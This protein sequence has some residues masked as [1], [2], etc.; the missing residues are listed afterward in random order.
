MSVPLATHKAQAIELLR[1]QIRNSQATGDQRNYQPTGLS[2]LDRLLPGG[3]I[4]VGS[5]IEWVSETPGHAATSLALRSAAALLQRPGCIAVIDEGRDFFPAVAPALDIPLSRILLVQVPPGSRPLPTKSPVH[6]G[7]PPRQPPSSTAE[8]HS[9]ALWALEQTA[10]CRGVRV[11]LGWLDRC[12]SAVVRRLQLAV[13]HSGVTVMLVRPATALKQPS[14]ADLRLK[15]HA[16]PFLTSSSQHHSDHPLHT[17]TLSPRFA[18]SDTP[19]ENFQTRRIQV[20]L[21]RVRQGL[22]NTGVAEIQQ[23]W[24][25]RFFS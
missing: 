6:L 20:Q 23:D 24:S 13:E 5:V 22:Q 10:R 17:D 16:L 2:T 19:P 25:E 3:G 7:R 15:V 1:R 8:I 9:E 4:P 18:N 14:F 21:M 12:T 11:V